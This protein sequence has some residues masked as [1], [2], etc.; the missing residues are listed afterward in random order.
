MPLSSRLALAALAGLLAA[1]DLMLDRLAEGS[2]FAD[3]GS[4]DT[5]A[6][7]GAEPCPGYQGFDV[8]CCTMDDPC[9]WADD[10]FCDC[11]GACPWDEADCADADAPNDPC[12][13]YCEP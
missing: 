7:A 6:D 9:G 8:E 11:D 13:R 4:E 10:G 2:V 3:A 5:D 12:S 1:C